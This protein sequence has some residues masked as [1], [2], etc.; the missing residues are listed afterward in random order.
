MKGGTRPR[1][2]DL[3]GSEGGAL[4][5]LSGRGNTTQEASHPDLQAVSGVLSVRRSEGGMRVRRVGRAFAGQ[6]QG[7]IQKIKEF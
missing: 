1:G 7:F 6:G 3:R 4:G 2:R 5:E